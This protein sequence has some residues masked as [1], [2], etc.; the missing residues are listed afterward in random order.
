MAPRALSDADLET[1]RSWPP[2]VAHSDL[3]E[4][5]TLDVDDLRWVR[6]HRGAATRL[7]LAVQLCGLRFLGFVPADLASTPPDVTQ[8]LAER[9]RVAPS[10]LSRYVAT[11]DGR[12]RRLHVASVVE[13][14]GWRS[15]GR[16][17]RKRLAD[18]LVARALEHDDPSLLFAQ[19]LEHLR[20]E[21]VVRPGLDRLQREI[22]E[23]RAVAHREILWRLRPEL[24][25]ECCAQLDALAT[26]DPELGMAPL[27]WLDKG[28]VSSTPDAIKAE[29]AKLAYLRQLGADRVD[30]SAL[31]PERA[32]QLAAVGRRSKPKDLRAMA[33]ERRHPILLATV[34]GAYA[35]ILDELVQML[36]RALA[37]TSSRARSEIAERQLAAAAANAER[38]ELLDE[39]LEVALDDGLDDAGVGAGVR[40][41]GRA[42]LAGAVRAEA[43]RTPRD[44]GHLERIEAR[45]SHVRSFAPHALAALRLRSSGPSEVFEAA[46]LLQAMNAERRRQ[47]PPDAPVGFVP[48]RWRPYLAA[49]R[50]AGDDSAYRHYRELCVLYGLRG[51]LRSGEVWVEGSRRYG[52]VASY[53]IPVEEWPGRRDEVAALCGMPATFA[54]RLARLDADYERLLDQLEALLA[55]GQGPV[56]IDDA[57]AGSSSAPWPPRS[58]PPRSRPPRTRSWPACRWCPSP[59][60]SSRWTASLGSATG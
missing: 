28:A 20:A 16:S 31:P 5:F 10:A 9:V 45:Y 44:G 38:L 7:G 12:L 48:S 41:L 21:H 11:V 6:S 46:E 14:A 57:G 24:S 43:E 18:W 50:A 39:I 4:Y 49:A 55:D 53:L 58:S 51:A 54:E 59:R 2:E 15:C 40:A 33:P 13:R 52:D 8:R 23:A 37:A 60:R 42:R 47:L 27:T 22:A 26:N 17:E 36:D 56:R 29:V 30:L 35:G 1:L 19:A 32:R 25:P 34:A 3:V